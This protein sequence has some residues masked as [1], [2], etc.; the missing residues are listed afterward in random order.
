MAT[1]S[2]IRIFSAAAV[3]DG[4]GVKLKRSIGLGPD[5]RLD[6]FLLLDEM[7]SE[8]G[9]DYL[10]GFP[11]HP[12]RGFETVT[13]MIEGKMRHEDSM[14]NSG[15]L[16][17]GG[18]QWMTAGRGIIHSEM[19]E[20]EGGRLHG[21]QLW[22][23]LP[24][25]DKM[26]APRYQDI[27]PARIPELDLGS[28]A[29]A[30]LIAGQLADGVGPVEGIGTQP[31]FVDLSLAENAHVEIPLP[32][33]HNAFVYCFE[34]AVRVGEDYVRDDHAAIL[35]SGGAARLHSDSGGRCLL[36]AAKPIGEPVV[37]HGPFV[38]NTSEEIDRA[39]AAYREG[40]FVDGG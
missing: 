28:G 24:A 35:S 4:A 3:S 38:M 25:A 15:L 33:S 36:L 5:N 34:G 12:H 19:P 31:L 9:S 13:Y 2:T 11:M 16:V 8:E 40:T 17:S 26:Q 20:Q 23:N 10:G 29:H 1:R 27:E 37:Q 6:P 14:G 18:A 39:M 21:F 32:E 22:V 7:D 30:R